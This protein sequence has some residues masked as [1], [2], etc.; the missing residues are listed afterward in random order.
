[1]PDPV[2]PIQARRSIRKF[3]DRPVAP[4]VV[5]EILA[6]A[7]WSPSWGNTQPWVVVVVTGEVLARIKQANQKRVLDGVM[8]NPDVTMPQAWPDAHRE[9]YMG[10]GRS[11][12]T[13]LG[14]AR[15]DKQA[16]N[17]FTLGMFGLFDAPCLL[18]FCM[19]RGLSVPYA[20][21]DMGM[22]LHAVCLSARAKGLGTCIMAA[23]VSYPELLRGMLPIADNRLCVIG[24]V[25][26]YPDP[27]AP[28]NH[29]PRER[30]A[31]EEFVTWAR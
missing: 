21:L 31:V 28:I 24:A 9:R 22:F 1:M 25:L 30:L 29:F 13:A 6:E 20:C 14:I 17:D 12:F 8:P 4:A 18:L 5:R 26:G 7:G 15:E 19:D 10:M 27:D 11:I 2:D 16:R 3:A 23:T